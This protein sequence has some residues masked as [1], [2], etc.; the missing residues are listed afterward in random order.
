MMNNG[1]WKSLAVVAAL[2]L[3]VG[4]GDDDSG[5]GDTVT[6]DN[7]ADGTCPA[8]CSADPDCADTDMGPVVVDYP[9]NLPEASLGMGAS[10]QMAETTSPADFTCSGTRTAPT[11]GAPKEFTI[12][13]REFVS[14]MP[15]EGLCVQFFDDNMVDLGATCD[16]LMTDAAGNI[17][18]TAPAG[19]WYAY[20]LFPRD[21]DAP[22]NTIVDTL[23]INEE[24]PAGDTTAGNSVSAG[25]LGLI[26]SVLGLN[27]QDGTALVA[28]TAQ[29][30]NGAPVYG[31][32]VR[33]YTTDGTLLEETATANSP[34][35]RY[36]NGSSF[37]DG[38]QKW[39]HVDG[40]YAAANIP[41]PAA[42]AQVLVEVSGLRDGVYQVIGC[43]QVP[44]LP[45][46]VSIVNVGPLRADGPSCPGM[47]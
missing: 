35:Y 37:P 33:M 21:G 45:N 9:E 6:C 28:G 38:R 13:I 15:F 2:A 26:P 22:A 34:K 1:N 12:E 41:S 27:R 16:G 18:V 23:Q 47:E 43:E 19:G 14:D 24:V 42:G 39:T 20:R 36:F 40:L 3:G 5:G 44:I 32:I 30:C 10:G 11:G 46:A 7:I 25:T 29:D 31:G 8:G 4:C 17:T